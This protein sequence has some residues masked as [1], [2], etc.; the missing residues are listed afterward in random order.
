MVNFIF[1]SIETEIFSYKCI[2]ILSIVSATV[3][4]ETRI[5][6][7]GSATAANCNDLYAQ[8]DINGM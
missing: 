1:Y 5:L 8:P 7:G 3:A 4:N 2:Y 6:Y